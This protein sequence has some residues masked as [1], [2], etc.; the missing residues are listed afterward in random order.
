M[1]YCS[2]VRDGAAAAWHSQ[3]LALHQGGCSLQFLHD[4]YDPVL[5]LVL[6][7]MQVDHA[8]LSVATL[9]PEPLDKMDCIENAP[10]IRAVI[11]GKGEDFSNTN[12]EYD[13]AAILPQTVSGA[14]RLPAATVD[15]YSCCCCCCC[16][17]LS[18]AC[19]VVHTSA[20]FRCLAGNLVRQLGFGIHA[21]VAHMP[22]HCVSAR[23]S[24]TST[25]ASQ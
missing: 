18:D 24:A 6:P 1:L 17:M 25:A 23:Y 19:S 14:T 7:S 9:T 8:Y 22:S 4:M 5:K 3:E 13:G 11:I 10:S 12:G 2:A 20:A 21:G 16:C 15:Q